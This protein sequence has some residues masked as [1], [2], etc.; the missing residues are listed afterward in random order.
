M[1]FSLNDIPIIDYLW[2][3]Y[4]LDDYYHII[5]YHFT[6]L[7]FALKRGTRS[8]CTPCRQWKVSDCETKDGWNKIESSKI[9]PIGTARINSTAGRAYKRMNDSQM[10][11]YHKHEPLSLS[12]ALSLY[13]Y[14]VR[15]E[16]MYVHTQ[17]TMLYIAIWYIIIIYL[18]YI[19][20]HI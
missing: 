20:I 17:Y 8:L 10:M 15:H 16:W 2:Y 4:T 11:N 1:V 18:L 13:T 14:Y 6:C 5:Y 7:L 19:C 12:L 9:N 3:Y